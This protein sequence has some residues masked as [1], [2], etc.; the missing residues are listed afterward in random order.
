MA[1]TFQQKKV[2]I[3]PTTKMFPVVHADVLLCQTLP[4]CIQHQAMT[5]VQCLGIQNHTSGKLQ[6]LP[7]DLLR[8]IV[9]QYD[10]VL[11]EA[12]GSAGLPCKGWLP[13]EPVIPSYCTHTA[14]I[15][16]LQ[17]LGQPADENTVHRLS[18][19]CAL[20]N[21]HPGTYISITTLVEM[22]CAPQ[23]MLKNS[24]GNCSLWINQVEDTRSVEQAKQLIAAICRRNPDQLN[25]F[26]YGSAKKDQWIKG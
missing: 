15:V 25:G 7:Q 16:T 26:F 17:A 23:G 8:A 5:G 22:I 4:A 6:S 24:R 9:P 10:I 1:H 19:F 13:H 2:L 11:M 3:T 20:T 14:A 12:D 18:A 21:T